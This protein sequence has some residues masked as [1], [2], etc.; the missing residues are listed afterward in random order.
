MK[1]S[2]ILAVLVVASAA[3]LITGCPPTAPT[4]DTGVKGKVV[5]L[6]FFDSPVYLRVYKAEDVETNGAFDKAKFRTVLNE[7]TGKP[8]PVSGAPTPVLTDLPLF[9]GT[10]EY[11]Y[12][13]FLGEGSYYLFAFMD[14]MTKNGEYDATVDAAGD[15][16][17]SE[18]NATS[19]KVEVKKGEIKE[20]E[21]L[22][23]DMGVV[24]EG[25]AADKITTD[26]VAD[27][28]SDTDPIPYDLDEGKI[29]KGHIDG[30]DR[31]GSDGDRNTMGD[32]YDFAD[33]FRIPIA[34]LAIPS[35]TE[36]TVEV[37]GLSPTESGTNIL[38]DVDLHIV[39]AD[40]GLSTI[41][42]ANTNS[43]T[44]YVDDQGST[45]GTASENYGNA[46]EKCVFRAKQGQDAFIRIFIYY[47]TPAAPA[48]SIQVK[49]DYVVRWMQGV[50]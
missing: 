47:G 24:Y 50:H 1:R 25:G 2:L 14:T 43:D 34:N 46:S 3:F 38:A 26:A 21:S 40:N 42:G 29:F 15:E 4:G 5:L 41:P 23:L 33:V 9:Y 27:S 22:S 49:T 39:T 19:K 13:F 8:E 18:P 6:G 10:S 16:V 32:R 48:D 31:G 35:G 45:K 20:V 7:T 44:K 36:I 30:Y 12:E 37:G 17:A 28:V 11:S